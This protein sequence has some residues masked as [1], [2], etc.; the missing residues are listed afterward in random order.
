MARLRDRLG[1]DRDGKTDGGEGPGRHTDRSTARDALRTA[2]R[3]ALWAFLALVMARG[4][5]DILADQ[6]APAGQTRAQ[7]QPT[8]PD[9]EAQAFAASF[10]RVYLTWEP[11]EA[12]ALGR[13]LSR[14]APSG[15]VERIV[16]ELP[17]KGAAQGVI[18]TSIARTESLSSD[19][20]LVTVACSLVGA[21]DAVRYLA[22]PVAR[23][24]GGGLVVD[25]PPALVALPP[26]ARVAA[27]VQETQISGPDAAEIEALAADFL[28]AYLADADANDLERLLAPGVAIAQPA[29]EAA[30]VEVAGVFELGAPSSRRRSVVADARVRTDDGGATYPLRYRLE[31][32]RTDRWYVRSVAGGAS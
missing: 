22:V 12:E 25:A 16:P 30:A 13:R 2:G 5:G 3:V 27:P 11:G 8:F 23:G 15:L 18:E 21:D 9:T 6:P 14:Y 28:T 7:A 31:L 29:I 26:L 32:V 17:G 19:R 20:G 1:G 24:P 10:A 4:I